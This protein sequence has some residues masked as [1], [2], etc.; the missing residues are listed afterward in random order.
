V[1]PDYEILFQVGGLFLAR[2]I[3]DDSYFGKIFVGRLRKDAYE[4][5]AWEEMNNRF[6]RRK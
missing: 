1:N 5:L 2:W 3:T 4:I 6:E